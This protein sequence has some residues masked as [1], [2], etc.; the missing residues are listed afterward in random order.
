MTLLWMGKCDGTKG[1]SWH[2]EYMVC[3]VIKS[4]AM[5]SELMK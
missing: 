4:E 1:E 5:Q 2:S 3:N